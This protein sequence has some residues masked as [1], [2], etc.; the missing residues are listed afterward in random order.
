MLF[1]GII[2]LSSAYWIVSSSIDLTLQKDL[3]ISNCIE[4]PIFCSLERTLNDIVC[5]P[6]K[7]IFV[8][9]ITR[10][11]SIIVLTILFLPFRRKFERRF[12][13]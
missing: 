10:I 12:R 5:F 11:S 3:V 9:Y 8:D 2:V 7:G 6:E 13:Q 4:H 1:L